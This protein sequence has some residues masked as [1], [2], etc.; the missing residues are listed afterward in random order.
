MSIE[1]S[2][3]TG[4]LTS[5]ISNPS[6][7]LAVENRELIRQ[8]LPAF[9]LPS[10]P[11][12]QIFM[13]ALQKFAVTEKELY[14][15]FWMAYADPYVPASGIEFRHLWKH[16]E[17]MRYGY[18][19]RSYTYEEMHDEMHKRGIDSTDAFQMTTEKDTRGR[20]KWVLK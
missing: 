16:I 20:P 13:K 18:D 6:D 19:R 1:K 9:N 5:F 8:A 14:E 17:V 4:S 2:K 3:Q 12:K 15:A 10:A 7:G 11:D